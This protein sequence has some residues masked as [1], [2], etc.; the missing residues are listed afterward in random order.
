M[1]IEDLRYFCTVAKYKNI[2]RAANMLFISSSALSRH[3][4]SLEES[5]GVQLLTRNASAVDLTAAGKYVQERAPALIDVFDKFQ[6]SVRQ[7]EQ[8]HTSAVVV[9]CIPA[10]NRRL[11]SAFR[12]FSMVCPEQR[13]LVDPLQTYEILSAVIREETDVGISYAFELNGHEGNIRHMPLFREHFA[14][15]ADNRH[16]F[17]HMESVTVDDLATEYLLPLYRPHPPEGAFF[18]RLLAE[19]GEASDQRLYAS[20]SQ[21]AM[22]IKMGNGIAVLPMSICL[23][24]GAGC[25]IVPIRDEDA[26]TD[27]V[28]IWRDDSRAEKYEQFFCVLKSLIAQEEF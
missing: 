6:D 13:L 2:S 1:T 12:E 14:V 17:S 16:R 23:E 25:V 20:P 26:V 24:Y 5:L 8:M 7:I 3:I 28:G 19:R 18:A 22:Q 21:L 27:V 15:L 4:A 9:G 10:Y 11:F